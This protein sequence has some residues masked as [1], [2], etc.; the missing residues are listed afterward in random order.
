[1]CK[2]APTACFGLTEATNIV[3][4]AETVIGVS[5]GTLA[6]FSKDKFAAKKLIAAKQ[7]ISSF[8]PRAFVRFTELVYLDLSDN[9]IRSFE[10]FADL[11]NLTYLSV[12]NN[13]IST[14][15]H[16]DRLV[17]LRGLLLSC[18]TAFFFIVY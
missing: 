17:N 5:E 7:E 3:D 4:M 18:R 8:A 2:S 16:V 12:S 9:Q 1:M 11:S 13:V 15:D 14:I 10:P 6:S